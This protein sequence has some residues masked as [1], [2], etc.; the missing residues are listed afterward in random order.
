MTT[1]LWFKQGESEPYLCSIPADSEYISEVITL[2]GT[3]YFV[4][5]QLKIPKDCGTIKLCRFD[6]SALDVGI[7]LQDLR[8]EEGYVNNR[9]NP[10]IV[11][12]RSSRETST[13]VR[14]FPPN[15]GAVFEGLPGSDYPKINRSTLVDQISK[16]VNSCWSLLITAP[17]Y[18]G[19]TSLANLV[20]NHWQKQGESVY[21]ISF[22][23]IA[24]KSAI[25]DEELDDFF[26]R[27]LKM[28]VMEIMTSDGY[29]ITD[30]TQVIY[31][32][33]SFW[34]HLKSGASPIVR[35]VLSFAVFGLSRGAGYI[36]SPA[37]FQEKWYYDDI[38]LTH[39]ECLELVESYCSK[40][41]QARDILVP[42]ILGNIFE[43][44]NNHPGLVYLTLYTLCYEFPRN[45]Y[46]AKTIADFQ[47]I[48][49]KGELLVKLLQARCFSLKYE[50]ILEMLGERSDAIMGNLISDGSI[51]L[52]DGDDTLGNLNRCGMC[53]AD[54]S[55]N[56]LYF[57]S[58]IMRVFYRELYYKALYGISS[59]FIV[60][61]WQDE[62]MFSVLR[63][64]LELFQPQSL[65]NSLSVGRNGNLYERIYQDEF[66]R[67]CFLIAPA[68]CHPDVG[69]IYGSTGYLDFYIDGDIQLGFELLR[70]GVKI[71]GHL[72][73]FDA[74][75]GIYK[76]IPLHDY[77]VLDFYQV[78]TF[79]GNHFN[80][81]KYY[82]AVFS[83]D[84]SSIQLWQNG[85]AVDIRCGRLH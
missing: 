81:D 28:S 53:I 5:S 55:Q 6:G 41:P 62:T 85:N 50:H 57:A 58:E 75:N 47:T 46:K 76:D 39:D 48:I 44:V 70:N 19:K 51:A 65:L 60:S 64:I 56:R 43:F 18:T 10:M 84:F 23:L 21:F 20:Y 14:P 78:D 30:E 38:K 4:R 73:R 68:K 33:N 77:A 82:A 49:V 79:D 67:S 63:R 83:A 9:N 45:L 54:R 80:G 42:E 16:Q 12:I 22:A 59:S 34:Q 15:T 69:A 72:N 40:L 52:V 8:R 37:V 7:T 11:Q 74:E 13:V 24:N 2:I 26:K 61:N 32:N 17:S 66:Y 27:Q 71:N 3:D 36:R 35:K 29:L 25:S 31:N 1:K